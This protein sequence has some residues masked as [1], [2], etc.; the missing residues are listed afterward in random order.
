[1][2]IAYKPSFLRMFK[3]LPQEL[4]EEAKDKIKLF[5]DKKNH[6]K[7]KAHALTGKLKGFKSFS[8]NYKYR[9]I[10]KTEKKDTAI[11]MLIG[12]HDIYK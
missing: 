6:K 7:L 9:I 4:Q 12:S 5:K 2:D 10:F 11:L 3:K 8:V 1:M